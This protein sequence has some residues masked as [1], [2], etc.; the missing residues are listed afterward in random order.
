MK[1][2]MQTEIVQRDLSGK[3]Y[4]YSMTFKHFCQNIKNSFIVGYKC[5]EKQ[6]KN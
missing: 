1:M 3:S 4:T 5:I 6:A 2:T